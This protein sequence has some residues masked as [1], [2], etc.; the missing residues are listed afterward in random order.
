MAYSE[1]EIE[2][3]GH[4]YTRPLII[5]PSNAIQ[6]LIIPITINIYNTQQNVFNIQKRILFFSLHAIEL[7]R[8]HFNYIDNLF[9]KSTSI[10][11]ITKSF[12]Y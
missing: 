1:F 8:N 12:N 11:S 10:G 9:K 4:Y 3:Y 5:L 6:K 2:T 7:T